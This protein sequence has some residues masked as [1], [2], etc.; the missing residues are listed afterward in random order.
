MLVKRNPV[1]ATP[2][3]TQAVGQTS[4]QSGKIRIDR[5]V[6]REHERSSRLGLVT[7]HRGV[8]A[9]HPPHPIGDRGKAEMYPHGESATRTNRH[10]AQDRPQQGR[11]CQPKFGDDALRQTRRQWRVQIYF[12]MPNAAPTRDLGKGPAVEDGDRGV[13]R[14][15]QVGWRIRK[16]ETL[17][18]SDEVALSGDDDF[19]GSYYGALASQV[20]DRIHRLDVPRLLLVWLRP[21]AAGEDVGDAGLSL[22]KTSTNGS[23]VSVEQIASLGHTIGEQWP[24]AR[25]AGSKLKGSPKVGW[26]RF[27]GRPQGSNHSVSDL[28]LGGRGLHM[29]RRAQRR[30]N[31]LGEGGR[32]QPAPSQ[33]NT[34]LDRQGRL[35]RSHRQRSIRSSAAAYSR[36]RI[37]PTRTDVL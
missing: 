1:A 31:S 15:R 19:F 27:R 2:G 25:E 6:G 23:H 30:S 3:P 13:H 8:L 35:P 20:E 22:N 26:Q 11:R 37:S 36:P 10:H 4:T 7:E 18:D 5:S 33:Q 21:A 24:I 9:V 12:V 17:D 34:D 14:G 16:T 28:C 29:Q 32:T